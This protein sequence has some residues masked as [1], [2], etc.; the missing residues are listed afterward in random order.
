MKKTIDMT[1]GKEWKL[2]VLFAIPVLFSNLFQTLYNIVDSIIVGNMVGKNALA[3]VSSSGN[4]IFLFNSFFIGL[5]SGAGVVIARYF[6]QHDILNMRK[7][8][9]ND[10]LIGLISSVF[11]TIVGVIISPH[12]LRLMKTPNDVIDESIAYFRIYFYGVAGVILYNTFAGILQALGDSKRP[13]IF[14]IISSI[15]NVLLDILFIK[16]FNLGVR[17]AS[18]ATIISQFVSATLAFIVLLNRKADYH[19]S[20]KELRFDRRVLKEILYNGIPSGIQNSVIGLAN[21]FVQ[22]NINTFDSNATAG[23]GAYAKIEGFAFLPITCFQLALATFVSQNIG[24]GKIDRAK[25]GSHFA[26]ITSAII[27]E[28]IGI[29]GYFTAPY[30]IKL[31]V[32]DNDP[33]VVENVI[34]N[35]MTAMRTVCFFYPLLAY[36]HT[37]AA[38]LRG[39][40]HAVIPMSVMLGVWCI[41]RVCYVTF[42]MN[43]VCH[44]LWVL[45]TA[46]PITWGI[47]SI[48]YFIFYHFTNW[49][50]KHLLNKKNINLDMQQE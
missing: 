39:S 43:V 48:I 34:K 44:E 3:A 17:G 19:L 33:Q 31:F 27:A 11:L 23:C 5:A 28:I 47:S 18:I 36:S 12:I 25:K 14:L 30:T 37:T 13:L 10:V 4:L 22:S 15:L 41:F 24:A 9:H 26:I 21:V 38:V 42:M 16:S 1:Q 40:G 50:N 46:Y 2:I 45:Y 29:I 6:G 49:P 35:G 20:L 32:Q 7:A 8:I